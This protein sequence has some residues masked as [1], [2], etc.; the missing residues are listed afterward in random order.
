MPMISDTAGISS[1]QGGEDVKRYPPRSS[2]TVV[3]IVGT[4]KAFAIFLLT[5]FIMASCSI[6]NNT[7]SVISESPT[8]RCASPVNICLHWPIVL[9]GVLSK[10]DS[11][12]A[13][14]LDRS[15]HRPRTTD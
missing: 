1:I 12:S 6:R 11:N 4:P 3:S 15:S 10:Q 9:L 7:A 14:R 5:A 13:V 8:P 2:T